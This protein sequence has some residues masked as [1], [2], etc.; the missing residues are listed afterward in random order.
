MKKILFLLGLIF[1]SFNV[2]AYA[3]FENKGEW[4]EW[5]STQTCSSVSNVVVATGTVYIADIIVSSSG[6]NSFLQISNSSTTTSMVNRST[7]VAYDV[8]SSGVIY[9][10][11]TSL[12]QGLNFTKTGNS[13][14]RIYWEWYT[15]P[16]GKYSEGKHRP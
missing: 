6:A 10:Y 7:S 11:R 12:T 16:N 5:R 1:I 9:P 3:S 8:S 13:C 2:Y 4:M 14:V 15:I